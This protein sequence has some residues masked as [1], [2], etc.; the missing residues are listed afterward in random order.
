LKIG[1]VHTAGSPCRCHIALRGAV[2]ALGHVAVVV[3]NERLN[4]S[5]EALVASDL[6]FEHSD[7]Y[8]GRYSLQRCVRG[9]LEFWGCRLAGARAADSACSDNKILTHQILGIAGIPMPRWSR[10]RGAR[11]GAGDLPFP[12]VVKNAWGHNSTGLRF[13]RTAA[14]WR[15]L[16]PSREPRL[17]EEFVAGRELTLAGYEVRGRIRWLPVIEV[18]VPA[19]GLYT[20]G[21]KWGARQPRRRVANLA[22]AI[23]G[24]ILR[25]AA[26]AWS[27][28]GIRDYARFD[29]RL[30]IDGEPYFLEANVR[31]SV[32]PGSEMMLAAREA[33]LRP[34]DLIGRI[35]ANAVKRC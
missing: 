19:S 2:R 9:R 11:G 16:R 21:R 26:R 7:T 31:P 10:I 23:L 13:V 32:E 24:R 28:L 15:R 29:L 27:M 6:V 25:F 12:R 4:A 22:P 33:G 18:C 1:I 35:I 30:G 34:E 3:E 8:C 5:R 20:Y 14:E 17:V